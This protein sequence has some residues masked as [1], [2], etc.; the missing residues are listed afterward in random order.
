MSSFKPYNP[1]NEMRTKTNLDNIP[2]KQ[3]KSPIKATEK[4]QRISNQSRNLT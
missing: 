2:I 4:N 1:G 3:F